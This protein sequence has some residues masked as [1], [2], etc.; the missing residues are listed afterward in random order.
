MD[1]S[2]F[3]DTEGS[4]IVVI[5]RGAEYQARTLV[6]S[7]PDKQYVENFIKPEKSKKLADGESY[8]SLQAHIDLIN[9][10]GNEIADEWEL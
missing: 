10:A 3:V 2:I 1:H 4:H 5:H 7:L 6:D 9:L 8:Y